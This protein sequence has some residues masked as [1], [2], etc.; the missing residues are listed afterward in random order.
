MLYYFLFITLKKHF[1]SGFIILKALDDICSTLD[2][3]IGEFVVSFFDVT[4]RL[5]IKKLVKHLERRYSDLA[6]EPDYWYLAKFQTV[7]AHKTA[8]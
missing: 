2:S 6:L 5:I 7:C 1:K 3:W 4:N 8:P